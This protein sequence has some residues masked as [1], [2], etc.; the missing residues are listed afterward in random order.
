MDPKKT[1]LLGY[2]ATAIILV[3]CLAN[4]IGLYSGIRWP[5]QASLLCFAIA[6]CLLL[7]TFDRSKPGW[8]TLV[9]VWLV[10]A[11]GLTGL[12]VWTLVG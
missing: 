12:F 11:A 5:M 10:I 6:M 8:R 1:C 2:L 9:I 7:P 4:A 3:G